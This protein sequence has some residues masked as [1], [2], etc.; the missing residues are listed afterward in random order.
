MKKVS[1]RNDSLWKLEDEKGPEGGD[2]C[3]EG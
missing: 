2:M 3:R 1:V